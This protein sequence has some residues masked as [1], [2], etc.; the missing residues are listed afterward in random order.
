L[1][2]PTPPSTARWHG[3]AAGRFREGRTVGGTHIRHPGTGPRR[4]TPTDPPATGSCVILPAPYKPQ[5]TRTTGHVPHY[6][7]HNGGT[8]MAALGTLGS[9]APIPLAND[10][11][12]SI[13]VAGPCLERHTC[14]HAAGGCLASTRSTVL[15]TPAR[16]PLWW[17]T[18][19][20]RHAGPP[21]HGEAAPVAS[22]GT[23]HPLRSR[24]WGRRG[25]GLE[26]RGQR[27]RGVCRNPRL[28]TLRAG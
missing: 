26:H 14:A 23:T 13:L 1:P 20:S 19:P 3:G 17:H 21:H 5:A 24:R 18:L 7:R 16:L 28:A 8:C 25:R 9:R 27:S 12:S 6:T 4:L 15:C 10:Q 22:L 2:T 11:H